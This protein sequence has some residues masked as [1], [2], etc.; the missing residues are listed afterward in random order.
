MHDS[1]MRCDRSSLL[2]RKQFEVNESERRVSS[3]GTVIRDFDYMIADLDRQIAAEE[4]RTR[5][6]DPGHPAYSS[7]ALAAAKRRQ[8]LLRSVADMN[9]K[10]DVCK[11]ELEEVSIQLRD[12]ESIQN[13]QSPPALRARRAIGLNGKHRLISQTRR[14]MAKD[15]VERLESRQE[16]A[17][18]DAFIAAALGTDENKFWQA[19]LGLNFGWEV[20]A[21]RAAIRSIAKMQPAITPE[22]R[23]TFAVVW[24]V[25]EWLP[26]AV[27]DDRALRKALRFLLP[28]YAG[29]ART[30]YRGTHAGER[31]PYGFRWTTDAKIA[32][33]YI[34]R[35]LEA[36]REGGRAVMLETLAPPEAIICDIAAAAG[37]RDH[38]HAVDG[39]KLGAVCRKRFEIGAK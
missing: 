22:L 2:R 25:S 16:T 33:G 12:L 6:K 34:E 13:N 14:A 19:I 9:A 36:Q 38:E 37:S 18:V 27:G 28:P 10:L 39:S 21:W 8:N 26:L 31:R 32:T 24:V 23:Q 15:V 29:P 17:L 20:G 3:L 11:R 35:S 30:L 4:D 1:A 5:I 7:F